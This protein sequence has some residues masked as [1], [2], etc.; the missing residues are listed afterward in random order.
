MPSVDDDLRFARLI[1]RYW[2]ATHHLVFGGAAAGMALWL[3]CV[4]GGMRGIAAY[5]AHFVTGTKQKF[6][7][8]ELAPQCVCELA[9]LVSAGEMNFLAMAMILL[10]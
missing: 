7:S 3:V 1:G 10:T 9:S 8:L 6:D 2:S 5:L 4:L